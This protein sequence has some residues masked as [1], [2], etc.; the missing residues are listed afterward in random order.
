M[1]LFDKKYCSVC[2]EKIGLLGNIK[3]ADGNL[4]R[5]CRKKLSPFYKTDGATVTDIR[6]HLQY[7]EQNRAALR[8]FNADK[9]I[10][11]DQPIGPDRKLCIDSHQRKFLL[12]MKNE[13]EAE[14]PDVFDLA[15]LRTI[16]FYIE[17]FTDSETPGGSIDYYYD[18][19][20]TLSLDHP[21][22]HE[23]EF[24]INS[25]VVSTCKRIYENQ[26]REVYKGGSGVGVDILFARAKARTDQ[27]A[28]EEYL[29]YY[30][31]LNDMVDAL[32]EAAQIQLETSSE[33]HTVPRFCP[34]CG[35]KVSGGKFCSSCGNKLI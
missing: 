10:G 1:G 21:F 4:C 34:R 22:I 24:K 13:P 26:V 28:V 16:R 5:S 12:S 7:R 20:L 2:G 33:S 17:E 30:T 32:A 31:V 19:Y 11:A 8:Y 3:L 27:L 15:S 35:E 25:R 18:F 23:P 9:V 6:T 29:K 14:N